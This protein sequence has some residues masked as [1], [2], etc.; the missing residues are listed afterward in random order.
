MTEI[1]KQARRILEEVSR[2]GTYNEGH[3]LWIVNMA[4]AER[5]SLQDQ[6]KELLNIETNL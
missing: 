4:K 2:T 6:I 3:I 5:R 1:E